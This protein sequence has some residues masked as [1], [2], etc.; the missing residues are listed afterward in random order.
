MTIFRN[1]LDYY[2]NFSRVDIDEIRTNEFKDSVKKKECKLEDAVADL[3]ECN[4]LGFI[5]LPD[6]A[7]FTEGLDIIE[8]YKGL[9]FERALK[10]PKKFNY[11]QEVINR[12]IR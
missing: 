9:K 3:P 11:F 2:R 7:L 8:Y 6:G 10:L 12:W 5:Y 1:H 4:C